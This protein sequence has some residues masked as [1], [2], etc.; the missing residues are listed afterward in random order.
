MAA[1]ASHKQ[2][3]THT[4]S[5]MSSGVAVA[6]VGGCAL[7]VAVA[8]FGLGLANFA[9]CPGQVCLHSDNFMCVCMHL[10][11]HVHVRV[12]VPR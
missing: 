7:G 2:Q 9:G 11:V 6:G 1:K 8:Y 4:S 12:R 3:H 5:G 10:L